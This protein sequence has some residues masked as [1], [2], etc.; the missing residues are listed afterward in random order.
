[1]REHVVHVTGWHRTTDR[2]ATAAQWLCRQDVRSQG[3]PAWRVIPRAAGLIPLSGALEVALREE[4]D[5]G[6]LPG[7]RLVASSIE[8]APGNVLGVPKSHEKA[9]GRG[10]DA[11]REY[12]AARA[13]D[14]VD[15]IKFLLSGDDGF[16]PAGGRTVTYTEDEAR[17]IG[18]EI[19]IR[20]ALM[21]ASSSPT[22]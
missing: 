8:R 3:S 4:I 2:R 10:P 22:I 11:L 21:S 15:S 14:G 5:A 12:V 7:P 16:S 9:H 17:A 20:P 19:E 6:Y 13:K 1:M 18:E